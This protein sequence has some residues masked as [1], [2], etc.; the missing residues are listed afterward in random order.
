M[1]RRFCSLKPSAVRAVGRMKRPELAETSFPASRETSVPKSFQRHARE[2]PLSSCAAESRN[3]SP[4]AGRPGGRALVTWPDF[5]DCH[6]NAQR[7][8]YSPGSFESKAVPHAEPNAGDGNRK[9]PSLTLTLQLPSRVTLNQSFH[10]CKFHVPFPE[11]GA[12][13]A[14]NDF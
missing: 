13:G 2:R 7:C 6:S 12:G 4:R 1:A 14:L 8:C 10:F 11:R 3:R 9:L 5:P